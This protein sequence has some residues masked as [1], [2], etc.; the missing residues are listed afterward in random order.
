[1]H[2]GKALVALLL[3]LCAACS[4]SAQSLPADVAERDEYRIVFE[5][6][7]SSAASIGDSPSDSPRAK[8]FRSFFFGWPT[9]PADALTLSDGVLHLQADAGEGAILASAAP[10]PGPAG[11]AGRVFRNG[12]FFEARIALGPDRRGN[13]SAWPTFWL[14]SIEH[15]ALK[16]AARWPGE[17]PGYMR[18][19]E[20]DIFEYNPDWTSG[21]YYSTLHEWFGRWE[22]CGRG[23]W[24]HQANDTDGR[25]MIRMNPAAELREFHTYGQLWVPATRSRRGYVQNFL[26]GRPVGVRVEWDAGEPRPPAPARALFNV[27]DRQG[28]AL[29]LTSGTQRMSVDWVRVWQKPEGVVEQR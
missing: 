19:V 25:R 10:A 1:M 22:E 23:R 12:A 3:A 18:F 4:A 29:I 24:C 11:W 26:D 9:T 6:E 27:I 28:M 21:A 17:P 2:P 20:S 14:M 16:G 7:F 15:L 8:W 5:D 13:P